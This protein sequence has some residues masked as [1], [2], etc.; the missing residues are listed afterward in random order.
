MKVILLKDVEKVGKKN[1]VKEVADGY[2]RNF[3]IPRKLAILASKMEVTKLEERKKIQA[4]Q[5]E[6]E[7]AL[8][9]K[10]ADKMDG[11]ELDIFVKVGEDNKLFGAITST[12]ISDKLKENGF[13]IEK[14]QIKL[15]EPIKELGEYDIIVKFPHNLEVSIKIIV[16][17]EIAKKK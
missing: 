4:K 6:E 13:E 7:L 10:T 2:A 1:D 12:N 17:K 16:G 11:L 3:L 5:A 8:F 15:K 9:Q 14:E